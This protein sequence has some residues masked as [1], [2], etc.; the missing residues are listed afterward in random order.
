MYGYLGNK[1]GDICGLKA[2]DLSIDLLK[3]IKFEKLL[4][5][6]D[7]DPRVPH[8]IAARMLDEKIDTVSYIR[9]VPKDI[10]LKYP[11]IISV[12]NRYIEKNEYMIGSHY[13]RKELMLWYILN[14]ENRKKEAQ[15]WLDNQVT[16]ISETNIDYEWFCDKHPNIADEMIEMM[17]KQENGY[18]W[19]QDGLEY[20]IANIPK[21]KINDIMK[22]VFQ[23]K[24]KDLHLAALSNKDLPETYTAKALKV[25]A[26]RVNIPEINATINKKVL[27]LLPTIT[28]LEVIE[29][30]IRRRVKIKDIK[31]KDDFKT[32]F[33]GSIMR[34]PRRVEYA[35]NSFHYIRSEENE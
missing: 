1:W 10:V 7:D 2:T 11:N 24:N 14:E 27:T 31:N 12:Y 30:L 18:K 34:Y 19:R 25:M 29:R 35:V 28:R 6:L 8:M 26:K 17:W 20:M 9:H 23:S 32:L 33:L 5:C 13:K 21:C 22:R 16:I 4:E 15:K 3:K